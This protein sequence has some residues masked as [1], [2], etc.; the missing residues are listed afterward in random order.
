LYGQI[1]GISLNYTGARLN[2]FLC[3]W[4]DR[5]G[6]WLVGLINRWT[7]RKMWKPPE[8]HVHFSPSSSL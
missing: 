2:C 7:L 1:H 8:K 3:W 5:P 6:S 4:S